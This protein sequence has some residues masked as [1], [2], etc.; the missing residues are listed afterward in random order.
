[1]HYTLAVHTA[2]CRYVNIRIAYFTIGLRCP[3]NVVNAL[4]TLAWTKH[5][6]KYRS[7]NTIAM[8]ESYFSATLDRTFHPPP[9]T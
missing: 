6:I 3:R 2:R 9:K 5:T 1:M 7:V 8:G 4:W